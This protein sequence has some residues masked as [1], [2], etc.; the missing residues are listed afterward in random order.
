ME[1][2]K[3]SRAA[4]NPDLRMKYLYASFISFFIISKRK[5]LLYSVLR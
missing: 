1:T 4:V 3:L 2:L 5:F